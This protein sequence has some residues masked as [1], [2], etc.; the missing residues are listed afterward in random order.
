MK[1]EKETG[2]DGLVD[3]LM[4]IISRD[5]FRKFL[6]AEIVEVKR[7]YAKVEGVV[8]EEYTNFHGTAHGSYIAAIADFALGIAANS[9]NIKRFAITIKIDFLKPAF[10]GDK[11]IAEAFRVGGGKS[12]VFF[13]INV[14]RNGELVAKGDA[15]VYGREQM[16][17]DKE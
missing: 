3:E 5:R 14:F 17:K 4:E 2:T 9:E 15:I 16:V 13:E 7:G 11:L 6:G 8:K 10:P 1:K 12:V